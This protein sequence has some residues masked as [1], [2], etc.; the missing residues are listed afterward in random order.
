MR[1]LNNMRW[2]E[3]IIKKEKT[4]NMLFLVISQSGF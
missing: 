1:I 4:V 2:N 3:N